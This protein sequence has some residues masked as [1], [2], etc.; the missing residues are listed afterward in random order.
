MILRKECGDK[1]ID[2]FPTTKRIIKLGNEEISLDPLNMSFNENTLSNYL[3][4]EYGWINYF[5]EKLADVEALMKLREIDYDATYGEKYD[6]YK[7]EGCTEKQAE[8][9]TKS[10]IEVIDARKKVVDAQHKQKLLYQHLRAWDKNHENAQSR[11]H[12][13]RKEMDKLNKE[14]YL[15]KEIDDAIPQY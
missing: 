10:D 9:R 15:N 3:E 7:T 11:G 13:L 6:K 1:M 12:F 5:G 14:I 2:D 8:A 4:H